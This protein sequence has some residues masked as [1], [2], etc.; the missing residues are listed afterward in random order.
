MQNE[1]NISIHQHEIM[2][3]FFSRVFL[4]FYIMFWVLQSLWASTSTAKGSPVWIDLV[5]SKACWISLW[6]TKT[7]IS[8]FFLFLEFSK[9]FPNGYRSIYGAAWQGAHML[10]WA[11]THC[12][13]HRGT[14]RNCIATLLMRFFLQFVL[15][16]SWLYALLGSAQDGISYGASCRCT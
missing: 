10:H 7:T 4:L 6:K 11:A 12:T 14:L 2:V 9:F 15:Y 5:V 8:P 3:I 1:L 13:G 16:F